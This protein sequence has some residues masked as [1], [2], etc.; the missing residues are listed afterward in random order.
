MLSLKGEHE[1]LAYGKRKTICIKE[2]KYAKVPYFG[3]FYDFREEIIEDKSY[4]YFGRAYSEDTKY[5]DL[6]KFEM[7]V[8]ITEELLQDEERGIVILKIWGHEVRF[9]RGKDVR[10]KLERFV[11]KNVTF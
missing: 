7:A 6:T 3:P 8:N 9:T 2:W 11:L 10:E 4:I 5:S 1:T